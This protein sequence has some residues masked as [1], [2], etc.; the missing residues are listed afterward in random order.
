VIGTKTDAELRQTFDTLDKVDIGLFQN[1]KTVDLMTYALRMGHL[2]VCGRSQ[3][4]GS[5][6]VLRRGCLGLLL[7]RVPF[8]V[9]L[10]IQGWNSA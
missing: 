1:S 9:V 5:S 10:T 3:A 2:Q 7:G 4:A 8:E 6:G